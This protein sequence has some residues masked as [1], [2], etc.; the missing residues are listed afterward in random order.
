MKLQKSTSIALCSVLEAASDPSRQISAAEIVAKYGVSAH[1]LAKVL[2]QLSRSG[3][4]ESTRGAGGGYRFIGNAKRLTLYDVIEVFEDVTARSAEGGDSEYGTDVGMA[5]ALVLREIDENSR[6][7]FR[8]ITISTM[9][10]MIA[11]AK[12]PPAAPVRS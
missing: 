6:A 10:K 7:T 8:S 3:F 1:H 9:L 2:R 12:N 5:I 11:R 4:V